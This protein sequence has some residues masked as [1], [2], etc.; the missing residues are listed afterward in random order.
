MLI[1]DDDEL[2]VLEDGTIEWKDRPFTGI[3]KEFRSD[4]SVVSEIEYVNG[5]QQGAARH[6]HPSGKLYSEDWFVGNSRNGPSHEWNEAGSLVLD[7]MYEHGILIRE[8]RWNDEGELIE[9]YA[10]SENDPLF[11]TLQDMRLIHD[12]KS[13]QINLAS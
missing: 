12:R 11:K 3:A 5:V 10:I 8:K 2:F 6:Y 1:V 13:K 4:G 9:E 7:A